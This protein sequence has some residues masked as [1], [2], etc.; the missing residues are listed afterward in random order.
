MILDELEETILSLRDDKYQLK[1]WVWQDIIKEYNNLTKGQIIMDV[2]RTSDIV[3]IF[4]K[5][6][7]CKKTFKFCEKCNVI[8]STHLADTDTHGKNDPTMSQL[9][10]KKKFKSRATLHNAVL[11]AITKMRALGNTTTEYKVIPYDCVRTCTQIPKTLEEADQLV[12]ANAL[13]RYRKEQYRYHAAEHQKKCLIKEKAILKRKMEKKDEEIEELKGKII[14]FDVLKEAVHTN[15]DPLNHPE[16]LKQAASNVSKA[17]VGF[18]TKDHF[19]KMERERANTAENKITEMSRKVVD[20]HVQN[21]KL[22]EDIKEITT[23]FYTIADFSTKE[24]KQLK[25]SILEAEGRE[26][27]ACQE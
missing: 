16:F 25:D 6:A 11:L 23:K 24:I 10:T 7:H 19:L 22:K 4:D 9:L 12:Y 5:M 15:S 8:Y 17:L 27:L 21:E 2:K 18:L 13:E 26:K 14:K 20:Q 3:D 1:V